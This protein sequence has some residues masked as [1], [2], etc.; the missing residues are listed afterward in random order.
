MSYGRMEHDL[1]VVHSLFQL[2]LCGGERNY[3]GEV[4]AGWCDC[5]DDEGGLM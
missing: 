2:L 1:L 5:V 4:G 3:D